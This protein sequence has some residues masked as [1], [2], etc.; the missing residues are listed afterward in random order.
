MPVRAIINCFSES[1]EVAE[2]CFDPDDFWTGTVDSASF[3]HQ[4]DL[5]FGETQQTPLRSN[6]QLMCGV[7]ERI[8]AIGV[9]AYRLLR[10]RALGGDWETLSMTTDHNSIWRYEVSD[11]APEDYKVFFARVEN[12]KMC[13]DDC[14]PADDYVYFD[15]T[16]FDDG[17]VFRAGFTLYTAVGTIRG[18]SWEYDQVDQT[19]GN[20]LFDWFDDRCYVTLN[21]DTRTSG[22]HSTASDYSEGGSGAWRIVDR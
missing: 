15:G 6:S 2:G 1:C 18:H 10:E 19:T 22:T 5:E 4:W 17:R 7:E 9:R 14:G 13:F 12:K 3:R 11:L 16:R 20:L 8:G 21:F